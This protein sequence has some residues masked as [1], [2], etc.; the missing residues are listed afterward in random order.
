MESEYLDICNGSGIMAWLKK[1]KMHLDLVA[2]ILEEYGLS[3]HRYNMKDEDCHLVAEVLLHC[4]EL[5]KF[6]FTHSTGLQLLLDALIQRRR[7]TEQKSRKMSL[8]VRHK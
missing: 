4:Q 2:N 6:S 7:K 1:Y 5:E 3:I 8:H